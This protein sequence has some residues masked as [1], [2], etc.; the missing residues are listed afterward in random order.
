MEN[1]SHLPPTKGPLRIVFAT[2]LMWTGVPKESSPGE[3]LG[4]MLHAKGCH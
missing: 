3:S 1:G 2:S 4:G